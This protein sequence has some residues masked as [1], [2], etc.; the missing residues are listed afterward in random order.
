MMAQEMPRIPG[1]ARRQTASV[2]SNA[3]HFGE[4]THMSQV[5]KVSGLQNEISKLVK[6]TEHCMLD[7]VNNTY[8]NG[9]QD[10]DFSVTTVDRIIAEHRQSNLDSMYLTY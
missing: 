9:N 1:I 8:E 5:Q 6:G 10:L 2:S 7:K 4:A 3:H